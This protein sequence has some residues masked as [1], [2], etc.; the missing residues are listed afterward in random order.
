MAV[1]Y[2]VRDLE[3]GRAFYRDK[4]GFR[5]TYFDA[6]GR[7][8]R[9]ERGGMEIALAEGEPND[10]GGVAHVDVHDIRAERE[11][12]RA[13]GIEVGTIL[14]LH[15]EMRL[16]DVFDPDGNRVQLAENLSP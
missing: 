11:R 6:E 9:L 12:L 13:D 3:T 16:V 15:G 8:S 14:E 7:W 2:N 5:E 4:L 10:D 1:W